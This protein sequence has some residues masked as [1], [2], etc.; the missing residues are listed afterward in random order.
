MTR[1]VDLV[2][3]RLDM[4][5]NLGLQRHAQHLPGTIA[6]DGRPP[7]MSL[8]L[9]EAGTV[10]ATQV[11]A[12]LGSST[13]GLTTQDARRRLLQVGPNAVRS[14]GSRP[15]GVL[16]RQL[17]S[18]LLLLLVAA[19]LVSIVVGQHADAG[20]ILGIIGLSVGWGL[21]TSSAP[22]GPSRRCTTASVTRR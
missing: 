7:A 21:P 11:L 22:S 12:S 8:S 2:S 20:I 10:D 16:V 15:L 9:A 6:P 4:R 13:S 3:E 19:A 18:P 14:H 5:G 17:N 1:P